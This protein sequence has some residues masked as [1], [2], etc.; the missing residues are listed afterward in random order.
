MRTTLQLKFDQ[1]FGE[2][3]ADAGD[4]KKAAKELILANEEDLI[5]KLRAVGEDAI[6]ETVAT[7]DPPDDEDYNSES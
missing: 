3:A 2:A 6:D 1:D 5:E 7:G 4:S